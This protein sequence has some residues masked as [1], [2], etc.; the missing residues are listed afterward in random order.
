MSW[1]RTSLIY[2]VL[3]LI[4]FINGVR[5]FI[6]ILWGTRKG[7]VWGNSKNILFD[8]NFLKFIVFITWFCLFFWDWNVKNNTT[9]IS[10]TFR[11]QKLK[12]N[13]FFKITLHFSKGELDSGGVLIL[14]FFFVS[15]KS[16]LTYQSH[17]KKW[18]KDK[19][20]YLLVKKHYDLL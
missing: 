20:I 1:S 11:Q 16:T 14:N 5:Q 4:L 10:N 17:Q 7:N 2:Y 12:H 19:H 15:L 8:W 13:F 9:N 18:M 6:A 3:V